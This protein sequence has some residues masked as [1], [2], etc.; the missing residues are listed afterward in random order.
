MNNKRRVRPDLMKQML[1]ADLEARVA[2]QEATINQL[3][4]DWN[5]EKARAE[6]YCVMWNN[7]CNKGDKSREDHRVQIE[8]RRV[9]IEQ[10]VRLLAEIHELVVDAR[11]DETKTH[12][13]L[14]TIREKIAASITKKTLDLVFY[15]PLNAINMAVLVGGVIPWLMSHI[16]GGASKYSPAVTPSVP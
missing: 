7:E 16:I 2:N 13:S 12:A 8:E 11:F 9:V 1:I 4:A 10:F 15:S 3:A 6:K 5:K 14:G